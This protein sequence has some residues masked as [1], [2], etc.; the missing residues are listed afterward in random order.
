MHREYSPASGPV[1]VKP[2][3]A[4]ITPDAI[5]FVDGSH[6]YDVDVVTLGTGYDLHVPF[7][8][9]TGAITMKP[10]ARE[11]D[12]GL[13]TNL[14]YLFP[15]H[16]HI[17]S[18]SA[19]HQPNALAFTGLPAFISS[20]PSSFAQCI[21][22]ANAIVNAS[23]LGSHE[24][25]LKALDAREDDLRIQGYDPYHI[26]HRMI[27]PG[28]GFDYQDRL[29]GKLKELSAVPDDGIPFVEAWRRE[30]FTYQYL[31]RG[32]GKKWQEEWETAQGLMPPKEMTLF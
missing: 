24:M 2:E 32:M 5:V 26:G 25:L 12:R 14:R 11:R 27:D 15:L 9:V 17:F 10:N 30:V 3:I 8:E 29:I 4:Y 28:S 6:A 19:S 21:Y 13:T 7:L 16:E 23:L 22:A 20:C 31:K 1:E 18:L